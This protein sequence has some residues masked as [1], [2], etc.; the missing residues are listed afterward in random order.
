MNNRI[1]FVFFYK[2]DFDIHWDWGRQLLMSV[3]QASR[4]EQTVMCGIVDG[5]VMYCYIES[6]FLDQLDEE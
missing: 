1:L 5:I 6:L 4:G 2:K 3:V